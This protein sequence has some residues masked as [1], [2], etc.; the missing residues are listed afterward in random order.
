MPWIALFPGQG[1]Q[2]SGMGKSWFDDFALV[3][4]LFELASDTIHI[5]FKR[6]CFDAPE[7][8]LTQTK[9]TQPALL[10]VSYAGFA[11]L[12]RELGFSPLA[13][14]G[15]SLG[16]Y[17]AL[18]S[19]DALDFPNAIRTT[20][21]RGEAMARAGK[22]AEAGM[23]ALLG[24]TKEEAEEICQQAKNSDVLVPAN[25]NAPGQIVISGHK[26]AIERAKELAKEKKKRAIPLK[27]SGAF[28]SPL[29]ED[30]KKEL[31][32]F[33]KQIKFHEF[34][35]PVI[36]N[37]EAKPYPNPESAPRILAEQVISPV[38]WEDSVKYLAEM[39]PEGF[40]EIGPGKVLAGLVKRI[41]PEIPVVNFSET[42]DLEELEKLLK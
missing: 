19:A 42:K 11:I 14:A 24:V 5:N 7:S 20:R 37:L 8:E 15:H 3:R 28:H 29:M 23:L 18:C 9:N 17:T 10:L 1:S 34:K 41:V 40:I 26:N 13:S 38:R 16:E 39:N 25:F 6:L 30:A 31:E 27:V 2:H 21:L 33:L 36:S 22:K 35:F 32:E 4:E 12:K